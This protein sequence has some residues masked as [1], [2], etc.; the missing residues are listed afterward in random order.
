MGRDYNLLIKSKDKKNPFEKTSERVK[1]KRGDYNILVESSKP[2]ST[3]DAFTNPIA[4]LGAGT[5]NIIN[6]GTYERQSITQDYQLL[7]TLYRENWVVQNIIS[8]IPNDIT[9]KWF[10]IKGKFTPDELDKFDSLYIRTNLRKSINEGMRWGRLYGGAIGIILIKGQTDNLNEPLN[11]D[12]I[13][14]DSF[15]GLYILDRWTGAQ[16]SMEIDDNPESNNFGLPLYYRITDNILN[17]TTE[18]HASKVVRFIGREYPREDK[19]KEMYWGGSELETVYRELIRRD[20]TAENIASMV[21][22]SNLSILRVKDLEQIFS[23]NSIQAQERFWNSLQ[24]ISTIESS[25]GIRLIDSEEDLSYIN[26]GFTGIKDIYE[27]IMQDLSGACRIPVTK[28]F[29]RSPAGMNSTGES[30]LQNYYDYID[31]VR[32]GQFK[33]IVLKL[34]P[35]MCLSL[36]GEIREGL[37]FE[38]EEMETLNDEQKAQLNQ[39]IASSIIEA[40]SSNLITQDIAQKELKQLSDKTGVFSNITDEL[41]KESVGKFFNDLQQTDDPMAGL[42][43][44]LDDNE[45]SDISQLTNSNNTPQSNNS[46][47]PQNNPQSNKE[48]NTKDSLK[49]DPIGLQLENLRDKLVSNTNG[50]TFNIDDYKVDNINFADGKDSKESLL[51]EYERLSD[52]DKKISKEYNEAT[53]YIYGYTSDNIPLDKAALYNKIK[54]RYLNSKSNLDNLKNKI[55]GLGF[56]IDLMKQTGEYEDCLKEIKEKLKKINEAGQLIKNKVRNNLIYSNTNNYGNK[57]LL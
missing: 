13:T 12:L 26:Y 36:F 24:A 31:E 21:F 49:D 29:G 4:R 2:H 57:P 16:P 30:D 1:Y 15:L 11:Y 10:S 23:I 53:N 20:T 19:I 50:N 34:L 41:I 40:F 35:I 33:D 5:D 56:N 48:P 9:K 22:K 17:I 14:P 37:D 18:I 25:M 27:T 51:L 6:A 55:I 32:E 42:M 43:G 47:I 46:N 44:G 52:I 54:T 8:A 28:L 3:T 39:Q 38:F 45:N 7:N